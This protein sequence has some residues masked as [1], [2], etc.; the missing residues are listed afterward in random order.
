SSGV[1]HRQGPASFVNSLSGYIVRRFQGITTFG[2][3]GI[4]RKSRL[5]SA[6]FNGPGA[7][8][9]IGQEMAQARQQERAEIAFLAFDLAEVVLCEE[10]GEKLLRQVLR[11][12]RVVALAPHIGVKGIPIGATEPLQR[13]LGAG[14]RVVTSR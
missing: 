8:P 13:L 14:R 4:Q 12:L 11:I 3:L 5:P 7:V 6:A 2:V 9:L 1:E 10:P